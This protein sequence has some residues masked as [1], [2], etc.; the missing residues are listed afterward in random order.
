MAFLDVIYTRFLC[1]LNFAVYRI[2]K[3]S[4]LVVDSSFHCFPGPLFFPVPASAL[5]KWNP[6][7]SL[8]SPVPRQREQYI[9]PLPP[10]FLHHFGHSPLGSIARCMKF[11]RPCVC[12][13]EERKTSSLASAAI[14][15]SIS[16]TYYAWRVRALS[17]LPPDI[18]LW[19]HNRRTLG[20]SVWDRTYC[21]CKIFIF[22][23]GRKPQETPQDLVLSDRAI[24]II[25]NG[26]HRHS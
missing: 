2:Y 4:S 9:K 18:W 22:V 1:P 11:V 17:Y 24:Y 7:I 8:Y 5:R 6:I 21:G 10:Q 23:I 16:F 15:F 26:C 3:I 12:A 25:Q 13:R 20:Q 14:N 19:F